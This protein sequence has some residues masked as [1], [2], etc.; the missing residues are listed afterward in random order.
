MSVATSTSRI[1]YV[2]NNSTS[3]AYAVTFPFALSTDLVVVKILTATGSETTL[4]INTDYAVTGAGVPAGGSIVTVSAIPAT[5]TVTISREVSLIQPLEYEE[6]DE[7]PAASH[8]EALDRLTYMGQQ[9]SRRVLSSFRVRDSDGDLS[10]FMLVDSA[11]V[12]TDASGQAKMLT[13]SQIQTLLN[14]PATVIDQPTKTLADAADRAASVPDF[15]GQIATQLDTFG[16]YVGT[17][18]AEGG[19]SHTLVVD[20][21]VTTSKILNANVTDAKLAS[22]L[23]LSAKT[24]TLPPAIISGQTAITATKDAD[25]FLIWDSDD[26]KLKRVSRA[27][28]ASAFSPAGAVIQTVY[29]EYAANADLTGH[30]AYDDTDAPSN[31]EGSELFSVSITPSSASNKIL[32]RFSGTWSGVADTVTTALFQDTTAAAIFSTAGYFQGGV[33]CSTQISFEFMHSP[34]TTSAVTYHVR[35]G[36]I[37]STIRM[38][39]TASARRGFGTAKTTLTMQEIKG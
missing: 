10:P 5:Y 16:S 7:F 31:T 19:W 22:T 38:N 32:L 2:G 11:V 24:L 17:S 26:S 8:E 1:S 35:I 28:L 27:S 15:L 39:G 21:S 29:S 4:A 14:L 37:S 13:G 30:F 9:N 23:D 18:L 20:D 25:Y 6:A 3:T 12:G 36:A 34:S 33:G